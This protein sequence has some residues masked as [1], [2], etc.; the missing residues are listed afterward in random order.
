M[1][2][3]FASYFYSYSLK[4]CEN[5]S[6]DKKEEEKKSLYRRERVLLGDI[7]DKVEMS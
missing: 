5:E 1:P 2:R 4:L 6:L 7:N 3:V